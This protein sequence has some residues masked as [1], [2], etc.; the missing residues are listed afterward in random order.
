[1]RRAWFAAWE[2]GHWRNLDGYLSLFKHAGSAP[3]VSEASTFYSQAPLFAG[4]PERIRAFNPQARFIYVMRDPVER[5]I[6]HYWHHVRWWGERRSILRAI[7]AESHFRDVSHYARQLGAYLRCF[8]RERIYTLTH[9]SLVEDPAGQL[10]RLYAWLGVDPGFCAP[11]LGV[12]NNVLSPVISQARGLGLLDRFRRTP[13]YSRVAPSTPAPVRRAFVS[14]A[15]RPVHPREVDTGAVKS[16]LRCEQQRQTE[17]LSR[18]LERSFP[19]WK[20]LYGVSDER[21]DRPYLL[22]PGT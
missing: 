13:L 9:E 18:L 17:E 2:A 11:A 15:T 21:R 7:R 4:V 16:Y 14:I 20:T 1:L 3:V 10:S 5:T 12:P 22:H 19:E 8:E 6:S